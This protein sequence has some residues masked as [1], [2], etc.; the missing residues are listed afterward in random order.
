LNL[1]EPAKKQVLKE[2]L[3]IVDG[4]T[5][6]VT[7]AGSTDSEVLDTTHM[8]FVCFG[9]F[10]DQG[11]P[12]I[13]YSKPQPIN[14]LLVDN[15]HP[16][17]LIPGSHDSGNGSGEV[18]NPSNTTRKTSTE[19]HETMSIGY[20]D[21][22]SSEE[23]DSFQGLR[24]NKL[25]QQ[26]MSESKTSPIAYYQSLWGMKDVQLKFTPEALEVI[27]NQ[28][29]IQGAGQDGI[30]TILEKLFLTIK[31]DILGADIL[32]VE[33]T[34]DAV[35]GKERPIYHT[36]T[37]PRKKSLGSGSCRRSGLSSIREENW[38]NNSNSLMM[39]DYD[40]AILDQLEIN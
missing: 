4:T 33:I 30:G 20:S 21:G 17:I 15:D 31:F 27:A 29:T 37:L 9:N 34:E 2:I 14:D 28:A 24:E 26:L 19:S 18:P 40:L 38:S 22:Y 16:S 35:L 11:C 12:M 13:S 8:F 6:D 7:R 23:D 36:K 25:A 3:Q 5:I 32:S 39:T 1:S 10:E